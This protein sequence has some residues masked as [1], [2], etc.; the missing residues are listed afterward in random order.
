LATYERSD[1]ALKISNA[2]ILSAVYFGLLA[3]VFTFCLDAIFYALGVYQVIPLFEGT[4]LAMFTA[5][6]FGAIFGEKIIHCP[7]PY[8]WKVFVWGWLMTILALPFY[9]LGFVYFYLSEHNDFL[10]ALTTSIVFKFYILILIET[11][12]LIE[13]WLGI[14]AGF[15]AIYLRHH[16]IY[17]IYDSKDD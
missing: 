10:P 11:F 13:F 3:V 14:L 5:S 15:A 17:Y 1:R 7:Q 12:A 4:L 9:D 16:I 2:R 6:V 8:K